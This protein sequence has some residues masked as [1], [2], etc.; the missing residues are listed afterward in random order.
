MPLWVFLMLVPPQMAVSDV[1][2]EDVLPETLRWV[3]STSVSMGKPSLGW[4]PRRGAGPMWA[5]PARHSPR[6]GDLIPNQGC[7]IRTSGQQRMWGR[8][9]MLGR[10]GARCG[11]RGSQEARA[12]L[13]QVGGCCTRSRNGRAL[14]G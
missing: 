3:F 2:R 12:A 6:E 14:G 13:A 11:Q 9:V 8:E 10:S 7:C 4:D 5:E 1:G